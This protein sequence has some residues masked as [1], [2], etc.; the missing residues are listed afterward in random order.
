MMKTLSKQ[1]AYYLILIFFGLGNMGAEAQFKEITKTYYDTYSDSLQRW[2]NQAIPNY[3]IRYY[4]DARMVVKEVGAYNNGGYRSIGGITKYQYDE[5]GREIVKK[6]VADHTFREDNIRSNRT[7]KRE[8]NSIDSLA[9]Y[10]E[11]YEDDSL[12]T[13]IKWSSIIYRYNSQ[14]RISEVVYSRIADYFTN[15]S[16]VDYQRNTYFYNNNG[17]LFRIQIEEIG[18]NGAPTSTSRTDFEFDTIGNNAVATVLYF[19]KSQ[20]TYIPSQK[21]EYEYDT[22]QNIVSVIYSFRNNQNEWQYQNKQLISYDIQNRLVKDLR[23]SYISAIQSFFLGTERQVS[24]NQEGMISE[25]RWAYYDFDYQNLKPFDQ[26]Y[27][28]TFTYA[29]YADKRIKEVISLL[30]YTLLQKPYQDLHRYRYEY[31]TT[32]SSD[33]SNYFD[34]YLIFPNPTTKKITIDNTLEGDC[35]ISASLC[36]MTGQI[37]VEFSKSSSNVGYPQC[38]WQVELSNQISSGI[39]LIRMTNLQGKTNTKKIVVQR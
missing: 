31:E 26:H 2:V 11:W 32:Q 4:N 34:Q 18:L 33:E 17:R 15:P 36:D 7:I 10:S 30:A 24:Y 12:K 3:Y 13:F 28:Q 1:K 29:Y 6:V 39:Y 8:Y 19:N 9:E 14:K 38:R 20:N 22:N 21:T 5:K 25:E 23:Y 35:L 27:T 16:L 37:L